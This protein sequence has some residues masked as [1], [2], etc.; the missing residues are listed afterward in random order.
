MPSLLLYRSLKKSQKA[1]LSGLNGGYKVKK[2]KTRRLFTNT[3]ENR[4][5]T[6]RGIHRG[7]PVVTAAHKTGP[8]QQRKV[9]TARLWGP[10]RSERGHGCPFCLCCSLPALNKPWPQQSPA[11]FKVGDPLPFQNK[12][13]SQPSNPEIY[14]Q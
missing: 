11:F 14:A 13:Q 7:Q 3:T 12:I 4:V 8:A 9:A 10:P 6:V 1:P 5:T 2:H